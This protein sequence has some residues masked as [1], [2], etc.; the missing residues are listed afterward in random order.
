MVTSL[1]ATKRLDIKIKDAQQT[2]EWL[3]QENKSQSISKIAMLPANQLMEQ[4]LLQNEK[5]A[6]TFETILSK[7]LQGDTLPEI[8]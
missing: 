5:E 4:L 6:E 8:D 7:F 3:N 2:L 1:T